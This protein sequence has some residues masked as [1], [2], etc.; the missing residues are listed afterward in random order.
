MVFSS[1]VFALDT[2]A[3]AERTAGAKVP[4][5]RQ[6]PMNF[7]PIPLAII[8]RRPFNP[9][10]G[11]KRKLEMTEGLVRNRTFAIRAGSVISHPNSFS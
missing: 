3:S 4:S 2:F 10:R 8:A 6:E 9:R 7:S 5:P 11:I 1:S